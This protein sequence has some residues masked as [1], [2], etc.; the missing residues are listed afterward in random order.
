MTLANKTTD[1]ETIL[2]ETKSILLISW[3]FCRIKLINMVEKT[4]YGKPCSAQKQKN[5]LLA[6][7]KKHRVLLNSISQ[8]AMKHKTIKA[9][10]T[11]NLYM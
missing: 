10:A 3:T 7:H 1:L 2:I 9:E 5:I 8:A 11:M 4:K 6:Q